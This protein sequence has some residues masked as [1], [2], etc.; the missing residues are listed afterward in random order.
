MGS[1][2][3]D[4]SAYNALLSSSGHNGSYY[5][6]DDAFFGGGDPGMANN[7]AGRRH[8]HQQHHSQQHGQ[9]HNNNSRYAV[10]DRN[11]V[12]RLDAEKALQDRRNLHIANFGATWL[13]PPGVPKTLFQIREELREQEEQAET[14]RREELAQQLAQAEAEAALEAEGGI[15]MDEMAVGGDGIGGDDEGMGVDLDAD[16]GEQDLDGEIPDGDGEGF[17]FGD[18]AEDGDDPFANE[19]GRQQAGIP[20]TPV[21]NLPPRTHEEDFRARAAERR[22]MR[23]MRANEDRVRAMLAQPRLSA[24]GGLYDEVGDLDE[25]DEAQML[26]EDDLAGSR[27]RSSL[28]EFDNEQE[29]VDTDGGGVGR[30][31]GVVGGGGGPASDGGD[32]DDGLEMD[33]DADMDDGIPDA[34]M[35]SILDGSYEHTDTDAELSS[36]DGDDGS[37]SASDRHVDH[38][39][40]DRDDG[41]LPR[42]L[43][44]GATISTP[45]G[46][47]AADTAHRRY[48][49]SLVR[50]D[51]D[52]LDISGLL[53]QDGSSRMDSSPAIR[54]L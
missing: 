31:G 17:S 49:S 32:D 38:T 43:G 2:V 46:T 9:H 24:I 12:T 3:L 51:R 1:F 53:S 37:S 27:V 35:L 18:D 45:A 15:G 52:S 16:M 34:S 8:L 20:V 4:F 40:D 28:G 13:K 44:R 54:R 21:Q 30:D 19:S 6:A 41:D 25:E 7:A 36:I 39:Q 5:G 42:R 10:F 48:R 11:S 23:Q 26:Q 29:I 22:E 14:E 47:T 50:S 33:M